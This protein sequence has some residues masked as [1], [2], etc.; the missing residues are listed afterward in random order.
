MTRPRI[1]GPRHV[2]TAATLAEAVA[3]LAEAEQDLA[4]TRQLALTGDAVAMVEWRLHMAQR[5]VDVLTSRAE[6]DP[7]PAA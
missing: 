1:V 3:M 2:D 6:L 7:P 5:R 4:K